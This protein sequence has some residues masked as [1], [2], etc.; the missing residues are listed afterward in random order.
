MVAITVGS[1]EWLEGGCR[2]VLDVGWAGG[3]EG[4]VKADE[5]ES[6]HEMM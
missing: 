6:E 4:A 3:A 5:H 2:V 1:G